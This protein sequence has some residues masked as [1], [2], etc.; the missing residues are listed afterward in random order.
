[1]NFIKF[2]C[3]TCQK[4]AEKNVGHFN[5][6]NSIG[7]PV[8]CSRV[9][10]G[11]AR[12]KTIEEKRRIKAKYDKKIAKTPERKKKQHEYYRKD[13]VA[14]PEKYREI[15]KKKYPTHLKNLQKPE[16][17]ACKK[18]YDETYRANKMYGDFAE[19][20]IVLKRIEAEIESKAIKLA[21]G[22]TFNKSTQQRK[23]KWQQLTK[24]FHQKH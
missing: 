14:N 4:E 18:D 6:S 1:M 7:A 3:P 2:I 15:R 22:I 8:Y 9:C 24:V 5:R 13:Y 21:N 16:Y 10:A 12:R 11:I 17:K 20:A 23:R 19:A